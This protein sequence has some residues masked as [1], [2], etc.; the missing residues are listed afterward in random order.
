MSNL[1]LLGVGG[2]PAGG[3]APFSPSDITGLVLWLDADAITGLNDGD[4]VATWEDQSGQD[5]DAAQGLS[6]VRPSYET[7]ELNG[8]PVV[9]FDGIDEFD[10]NLQTPDFA[11]G[12]LSSFTV[13]LVQRY[14]SSFGTQEGSFDGESDLQCYLFRATDNNSSYCNNGSQIG[15]ATGATNSWHV[16]CAVVDGASSRLRYNAGTAAT[17]TLSATSLTRATLG[18]RGNGQ[19]AADVD[20]AEVLIYDSALSTSDEEDVRDYLITRYG[21]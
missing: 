5:N 1:L 6:T 11:G 3:G 7:N 19:D 8:L 20:I 21:L 4:P 17:G 12:S 13:F 9:S 15:P 18:I 10:D 16:L 2:K 14:R